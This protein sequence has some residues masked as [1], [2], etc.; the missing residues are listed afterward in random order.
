MEA[1]E[2]SDHELD[3]ELNTTN[4]DFEFLPGADKEHEEQKA[5]KPDDKASKHDGEYSKLYPDLRNYLDS[6]NATQA[7]EVRYCSVRHMRRTSDMPLSSCTV[8]LLVRYSEN[9]TVYSTTTR[10]PRSQ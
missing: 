6:L 10:I 4:G 8:V 2:D 3:R 7:S 5:G 9:K 1:E